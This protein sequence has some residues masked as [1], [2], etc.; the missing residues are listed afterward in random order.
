MRHDGR[1]HVI[2][3]GE[4]LEATDRSVRV[5]RDTLV[6]S[7]PV[8][9]LVPGIDDQHVGAVADDSIAGAVDEPFAVGFGVIIAGG[10]GR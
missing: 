9:D 8:L 5:V 10:R 3:R 6:A 2:G 7:A 1:A 4:A